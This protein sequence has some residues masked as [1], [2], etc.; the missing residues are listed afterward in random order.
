MIRLSQTENNILYERH[1]WV[2]RIIGSHGQDP[3]ILLSLLK[4]SLWLDYSCPNRSAGGYART[5]L[6]LSLFHFFSRY[7]SYIVTTPTTQPHNF[8]LRAHLPSATNLKFY[9]PST[10][11]HSSCMSVLS[12]YFHTVPFLYLIR[13]RGRGWKLKT[14]F[15]AK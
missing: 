7:R 9:S 11:H 8:S 4:W 2:L 14:S 3:P 6:F 13:I 15:S 12:L 1:H 5:S 10:E